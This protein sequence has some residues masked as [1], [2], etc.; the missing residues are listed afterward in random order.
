M[1]RKIGAW[2]ASMLGEGWGKWAAQIV[3]QQAAAELLVVL[4]VGERLLAARLHVGVV[5]GGAA[6]HLV[7]RALTQHRGQGARDLLGRT[8]G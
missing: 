8:F 5:G 7:E 2:V 6:V 3:A 1:R 4:A